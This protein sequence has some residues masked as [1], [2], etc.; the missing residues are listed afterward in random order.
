MKLGLILGGTDVADW[1]RGGGCS[2][3]R[4]DDI[5]STPY[6]FLS[7]QSISKGSFQLWKA[8]YASTRSLMVRI[9]RL[10]VETNIFTCK[11]TLRH[12]LSIRDGD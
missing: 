11:S 4:G 6:S 1:F 5:S 2:H 3:R 7:S 10:T 8:E 9:V 12:L